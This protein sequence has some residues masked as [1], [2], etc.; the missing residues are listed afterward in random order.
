MFEFFFDLLLKKLIHW[1]YFVKKKNPSIKVTSV[2]HGYANENLL[3]FNHHKEEFNLKNK[4]GK[5]CS[6]MPDQ[7]LVQGSQYA[8]ILKIINVNF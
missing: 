7:Y 6:P 1:A 2:H 5:N 4:E 3:F 8:N